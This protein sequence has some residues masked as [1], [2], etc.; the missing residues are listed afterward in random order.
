[1]KQV[2]VR[3]DTALRLPGISG[4][5][6]VDTWGYTFANTQSGHCTWRR[7]GQCKLLLVSMDCYDHMYRESP[8]V[9]LVRVRSSRTADV[10]VQSARLPLRRT[11]TPHSTYRNSIAR[12]RRIQSN[13]RKSIG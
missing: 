12:T 7:E 4:A 11:G 6:S 10:E 1:M 3:T 9:D 13:A 2:E 8:N 5:S